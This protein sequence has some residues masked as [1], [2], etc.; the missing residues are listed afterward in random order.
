MIETSSLKVIRYAIF[1]N[2][3]Y[4]QDAPIKDRW[5]GQGGTI[6]L[7][8]K[9]LKMK[10]QQ[11]RTILRVLDEVLEQL[12]NDSGYNGTYDQSKKGRKITIKRGSKEEQL[13]A[14]YMEQHCGFRMTTYIVNEHRRDEGNEEVSRFAIMAA[15]YRMQPLVTRIRKVQ[16]GGY[17]DNWIEARF[18]VTKQ[19][20]IMLGKLT[21]DEIRTNRH[22][23]YSQ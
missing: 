18:N 14:T 12:E 20:N 15:F 17:N 5:H 11:D 2:Y 21:D 3:I 22:G 9:D 6:S 13:I 4:V 19:M 8:R 16:S 7:I 23:A 10:R 1:Y